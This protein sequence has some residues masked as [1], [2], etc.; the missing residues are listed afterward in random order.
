VQ[1]RSDQ[2]QVVQWNDRCSA[3]IPCPGS[4]DWLLDRGTD[5]GEKIVAVT[6]AIA[7]H[8]RAFISELICYQRMRASATYKEASRSD[9]RCRVLLSLFLLFSEDKGLSCKTQNKI[10][11][12]GR[13][14][15]AGSA[16]KIWGSF[17]NLA[18]P[19]R[20]VLPSSFPPFLHN[21][22]NYSPARQDVKTSPLLFFF[23][24]LFFVRL[25]G[26]KR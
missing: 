3:P 26:W 11:H 8:S 25:P 13:V 23:F 20:A 6:G 15:N 12:L 18:S 14:W 24:F 9:A 17:P 22:L 1:R 5:R 2:G 10:A 7:N 4:R 19:P 16:L 21:S